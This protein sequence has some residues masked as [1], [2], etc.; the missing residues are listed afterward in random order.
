MCPRKSPEGKVARWAYTIYKRQARKI[1]HGPFECPSCAKSLLIINVDE[2]RKI[3]N[4]SCGCGFKISL[5]YFPSFQPI[6]YYSKLIDRIR[7][8]NI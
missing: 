6:D 2:K 4:G 5:D 8:K 1:A 7:K 3:V